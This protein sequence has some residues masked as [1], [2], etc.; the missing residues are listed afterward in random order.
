M[1]KFFDEN[2]LSLQFFIAYI[3][4][5]PLPY[6]ISGFQIPFGFSVKDFILDMFYYFVFLTFIFLYIYDVICYLG[7]R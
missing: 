4:L 6:V 7:R 1:K 5:L 2:P 3:I